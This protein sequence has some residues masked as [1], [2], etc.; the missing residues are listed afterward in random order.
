MNGRYLDLEINRRKMNSFNTFHRSDKHSPLIRYSP[1]FLITLLL[2]FNLA[3]PRNLCADAF[4]QTKKASDNPKIISGY[5]LYFQ[6]RFSRHHDLFGASSDEIREMA[7]EKRNRQS[8]RS[9]ETSSLS[10]ETYKIT[11]TPDI[12]P[13]YH[14]DDASKPHQSASKISSTSVPGGMIRLSRAIAKATA[15]N[16]A[17]NRRKTP[18]EPPIATKPQT[19]KGPH[20]KDVKSLTQLTQI[21]DDQL[22]QNRMR[23]T[24]RS[25]YPQHD[26]V[27]NN[28]RDSMISLLGFNQVKGDWKIHSSPKT[29]NIAVILGKSLVRDQV[30]VEYASRIRALARLFKE[31]SEFRPSLVCF[32]GGITETRNHVANADAGYIFFRH[33]CEAQNI[34]LSGV[35]IFIDNKS[36]SDYDAINYV[37]DKVKNHFIPDWLDASCIL[38]DSMQKQIHVHFIFISTEYHLCNMNDIHHRSPLQSAFVPIE[39]LAEEFSHKSFGSQ[40]VTEIAVPPI[41]QSSKRSKLNYKQYYEGYVSSAAINIKGSPT[42][43]NRISTPRQIAQGIVKPS[44]SFQYATYPYIF[45]KNESTAFLGKCYLLGQE[46]TPLLVNMHGVVDQVSEPV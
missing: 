21:I 31:D 11:N 4:A 17:K 10:E 36:Q 23:G 5:N 7:K 46:L 44:W 13:E 40:T 16:L 3:D 37:T 6:K 35:E 1:S 39:N 41:P 14:D 8:R 12:I 28:S 29:Y 22:Y 20:A 42:D 45:A 18:T 30:T 9:M 19:L 2:A 25:Y 38:S 27:V 43:N 15:S 33:M 32:S 26:G 24:F 34:D